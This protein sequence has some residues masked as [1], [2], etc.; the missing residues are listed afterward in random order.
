MFRSAQQQRDHL[1][2]TGSA[3]TRPSRRGVFLVKQGYSYGSVY[4]HLHV[5]RENLKARLAELLEQVDA[6]NTELKVSLRYDAAQRKLDQRARLV[7][8]I[9]DVQGDLSTITGRMKA[10]R[11][12]AVSDAFLTVARHRLDDAV[13]DEI[14]QEARRLASGGQHVP[15]LK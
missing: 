14:L 2:R 12:G 5:Q 13:F 9:K 11:S 15:D 8:T 6:I 7:A 3:A 10:I 1:T 4:D